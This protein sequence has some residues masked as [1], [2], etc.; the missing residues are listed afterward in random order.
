VLDLSPE[1]LLVLAVIAL[2]V[3]GPNRLPAAARSL[4]RLLGQLRAMSASLQTEVR[5]VLHEPHEALTN[6]LDELRPVTELRPG[7]LSRS[8]RRAVVDTL[9]PPAQT[10]SAVSTPSPSPSHA[11]APVPD[12]PAFN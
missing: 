3:L 9:T 5:D 8:V 6:A 2:M 12:D 1:K 4:G 11:P 10:Q 7:G